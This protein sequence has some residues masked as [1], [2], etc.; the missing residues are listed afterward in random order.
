MSR[1]RKSLIA[2]AGGLLFGASIIAV[3][4]SPWT[5]GWLAER[6]EAEA[7]A[8]LGE[9]VTVGR[10]DATVWPPGAEITG[11]VVRS[12]EDEHRIASVER[13]QIELINRRLKLVRPDLD[14]RLGV[15]LAGGEGETP[16][17]LWWDTIIV[18]E[19]RF[20]LGRDDVRVVAEGVDVAPDALA[21][22]STLSVQRLS[23]E[24]GEWAQ[25][26]DEVHMG[27]LLL[28]P[29]RIEVPALDLEF[30]VARV[31]GLV[32]WDVAGEVA[33]LV[34]VDVRCDE[35]PLEG[36]S[37]EGSLS[38][39]LQL[40]GTV[41]QPRVEAL[42]VGDPVLHH[43]G[44]RHA[45]GQI[46]AEVVADREALR[47]E[48]LEQ[49]LGGGI[50]RGAGRIGW[51]GEVSDLHVGLEG[52][53]LH[54]ALIE[55]ADF[56]DPYVDLEIDGELDLHGQLDPFLLEGEA[57]LALADLRV[58]DGG[59]HAP[60]ELILAIPSGSID[61][62]VAFESE[63]V[64]VVDGAIRGGASRGRISAWLP[65]DGEM[66]LTADLRRADLGT[67]RPLGG[68]ELEGRGLVSAR[69]HGPYQDPDID[70]VI[71]V[72]DFGL[73][74]FEASDSIRGAVTCHDLE[75]VRYDFRA[76]SDATRLRG[77]LVLDFADGLAMD[78]GVLVTE[79]RV[80]DLVAP[81]AELAQVRGDV[82]GVLT[83]SGDPS[84]LDGEVD[85]SFGDVELYGERFDEGRG[86]GR[87]SQGVLGIE[88]LDVVR[89]DARVEL[90]GTVGEGLALDLN[91]E[92]RARLEGLDALDFADGAVAGALDGD[93]RIGGSLG[94]PEPS[95]QL[96]ATELRVNGARTSALVVDVWSDAAG[97]RLAGGT[98]DARIQAQGEV[99]RDG[100]WSASGELDQAP[101]HLLY[102][103]AADGQPVSATLS[104]LVVAK[105][106][107]D[108]GRVEL[109]ASQT[110][111]AWSDRYLE[112]PSSW[113]LLLDQEG[114]VIRDLALVGHRT[115][116][117]SDVSVRDGRIRGSLDG[118]WDVGLLPALTD[119][120]T[121]AEG[122]GRLSLV[123]DGALDAPDGELRLGLH[124]ARL[125]TP[126]L[127]GP[128]ERAEVRLRGGPSA[129]EVREGRAE[130][131]GG[132]VE[133]GGRVLA[134][135]WRP[136]RY[137]LTAEVLD[138]RVEPL[139]ELPPMVG[140]ASLR[141]VGPPDSLVLSGTAT[142]DDMVFVE[143]ID[144]EQWAVDLRDQR[145]V[146]ADEG[147]GR[148][149]VLA[150]DIAIEADDSV[151]IR[152]NVGEGVADADLRLV[153]DDTQIGL[154]GTVRMEPGGRVFVQGREFL[155]ARAEVRYV[156]PYSYDPDLDILLETEVRGRER[157]WRVTYPVTG[158]FSDWRAAPRSDPG[159][160][161][162]DIHALLLFGMT[163][164]EL[165]S[166]GGASAALAAEGIDLLVTGEGSR[167]LERLGSDTL[168]GVLQHTRVDVISGVSQRGTVGSDEWRI[169]VERDLLEPADATVIGEFSLDDRYLALEKAL[170]R[171]LYLRLFWSSLERERSRELGG[172]YGA[173]V[174]VRWEAD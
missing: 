35:L 101:L 82:S 51:D 137:E 29:H 56:D 85:L 49:Q 160:P 65:Y 110:D 161:S 76:H 52:V 6:V 136:T 124:Q 62:P 149:P 165:E 128:L 170:A 9:E 67:F 112:A 58:S 10:V 167:A 174:E 25:A 148:P 92:I 64:R 21:G 134:E 4:N 172:A 36:M 57:S 66:D 108:G 80:E 105:G 150:L 3:W 90:S 153:G 141:L 107:A 11:L 118:A 147:A 117:E 114:L 100:R 93:L 72:R 42:I 162:A 46:R 20:A 154:V 23:V 33:G 8:A 145:L 5:A 163:R 28:G 98:R 22:R 83:L 77:E 156:D 168:T 155:V 7:E 143:R 109:T 30:P 74:G 126:V 132:Q 81:F 34:S 140:D 152:N 151:R 121:A 130:L 158:P 159:L 88:V 94:A 157:T 13:L 102:P 43:A 63:G 135:R 173:D 91:G 32:A 14:V 169:L 125:V 39:D 103:V 139:D 166:S 40:E 16:E 18:T 89:D 24:R 164:E 97:V 17:R 27:G 86:V 146:D 111:L 45:F 31:E 104:G 55:A 99:D 123:L 19:G 79:G 2:A 127:P 15:D 116:L 68:V 171:N 26:I 50:V 113:T 73:Y 54:Q 142:I 61:G 1:L 37:A 131:G 78:L 44:D 70:G 87:M 38:L 41:A 53:S 48:D 95:G 60:H 138:A 59:Q 129:W 144:W 12:K 84:A 106:D 115:H 47:I 71:D 96:G 69:V 75:S 133:V 120:F 122:I 119:A